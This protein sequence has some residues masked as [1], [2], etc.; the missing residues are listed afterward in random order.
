MNRTIKSYLLYPQ[1]S[2]SHA[3][4]TVPLLKPWLESLNSTQQS[5]QK[6]TS[7]SWKRTDFFYNN[8]WE[9]LKNTRLQRM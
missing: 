3:K 4:R 1:F 9:L 8:S 7:E 2:I 6:A 5:E